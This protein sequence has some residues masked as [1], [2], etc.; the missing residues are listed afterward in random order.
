V[1]SLTQ[2]CAEAAKEIKSLIGRSV[3][4]VELGT[5][6]VD[7][8]GKTMDE[9]V[10]SIKLVSDIVGEISY[11]S[12]FQLCLS[13]KSGPT[14]FLTAARQYSLQHIVLISWSMPWP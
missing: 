2:R 7:Q 13:L 11:A 5:S 9:I 10:G 3:E 4:Q 1:R 12:A 6:L 8:A 14:T